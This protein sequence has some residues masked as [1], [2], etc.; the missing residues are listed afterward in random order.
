MSHAPWTS[1]ALW[2]MQAQYLRLAFWHSPIFLA[3]LA[4]VICCWS[5]PAML[6]T[7][8]DVPTYGEEDSGDASAYRVQLF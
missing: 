4:G 5:A 2:L 7:R 8:T 3:V 1:H 6:Y